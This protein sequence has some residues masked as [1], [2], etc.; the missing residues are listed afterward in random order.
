MKISWEIFVKYKKNPSKSSESLEE[1]NRSLCMCAFK[2][3]PQVSLI[4]W[5]GL[6]L[7]L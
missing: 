2:K 1:G 5:L 7:L 3:S 4:D 6:H